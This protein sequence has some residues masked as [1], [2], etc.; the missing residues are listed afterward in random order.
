MDNAELI[1]LLKSH[2]KRFQ[3]VGWFRSKLNDFLNNPNEEVHRL[4]K[5][6]KMIASCPESKEYNTR[7]FKDPGFTVDKVKDDT[8]SFYYDLDRITGG[9]HEFMKKLMMQEKYIEFIPEGR[10]STSL[11]IDRDSQ[12]NVVSVKKSIKLATEPLVNNRTVAI[13]EIWHGMS[14]KD[15]NLSSKKDKNQFLGEIGSMFVD[16]ASREFLQSRYS[17]DKDFCEKLAYLNGQRNFDDSIEKARDGYLDYLICLAVAGTPEQQ[18]FAIKEVVDN[19][20]KLWSIRTLNEKMQHLDACINDP[21]HNKYDPMYECRYLPGSAI[22]YAL[23]NQRLHNP[24]T[25]D[26][27]KLYEEQLAHQASLMAELNDHLI[28]LD[29]LNHDNKTTSTFDIV[30]NHFGLPSIEKLMADYAMA[31]TKNNA[32]QSTQAPTSDPSTPNM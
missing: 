27:Q 1:N 28:T 16:F 8:R 32:P 30:T 11:S 17:S 7:S 9:K 6:T 24:T 13:H 3:S 2:V 4:A 25:P 23:W 22:N 18:D 10:S 20:G 26:E 12:G 15:F 31:I 29:A 19:V 21:Q 5:L 14:E